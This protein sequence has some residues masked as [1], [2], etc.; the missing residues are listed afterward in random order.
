MTNPEY[1]KHAYSVYQEAIS[2]EGKLRQTLLKKAKNI[3][4]NLPDDY[5]GKDDLLK[6]IDSMLY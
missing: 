1:M 6:R 5:P 4:G 3:L 2:A